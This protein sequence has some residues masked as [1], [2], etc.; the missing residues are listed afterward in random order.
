[1]NQILKDRHGSTIGQI[2]TEGKN[3]AIYDRHGSKLGYFDGRN[4]FDRHGRRIGEGN[5]LTT[6]LDFDK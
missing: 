5:L 6:L 4:T 2:K 3:E 1:M